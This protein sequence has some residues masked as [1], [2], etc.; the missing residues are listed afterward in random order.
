M[1]QTN[2]LIFVHGLL[3]SLSFFDPAHYL[4]DINVL[5]PDLH[6]YG[7]SPLKADLTL[8]DQVD[9]LKQVVETQASGPSWLL[10]HSVGGAVVNL[11]AAQYPDLVAGVINVEGNFTIKDAFWCQSISQKNP[12][13]WNTEYQQMCSDPEKWLS[14]SQIALSPQRVLWAREILAYQDADTVQ[15]VAK[16][17]VAGTESDEYLSTVRK[18]MESS[19]PVYLVAGEHSVGGWDV[20]SDV[21]KLA[22]ELVVTKDTGH[23]M[24]L[25][26]PEEFCSLVKRIINENK[27]H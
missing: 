19:T 23:M 13:T 24:M 15:A 14:D 7:E 18:V 11:F 1:S 6:G 8:Q 12:Q 16:A 3:G 9:Y 2:D 26:K 17:V 10:G 21:R 22:N 20:P 4:P 25:E 5:S 27:T